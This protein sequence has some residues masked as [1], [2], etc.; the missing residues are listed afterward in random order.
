MSTEKKPLRVLEIPLSRFNDSAVPYHLEVLAKH[1]TYILR[2]R[3]GV[4]Y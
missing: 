3:K 1:R 2:V 4:T